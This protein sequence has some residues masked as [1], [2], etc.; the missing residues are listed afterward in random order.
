AIDC[1]V[2]LVVVGPR[3]W[4]GEEEMQYAQPLARRKR[5]V[6]FNHLSQSY[7]R[8]LYSGALFFA[9]PSFYEGFGLPPLD[10]MAHGCPVLNAHT[11]SLPEVCGDAALYADP[12]NVDD[13]ADKIRTMLRDDHLRRR[14]IEKGRER[15]ENF[16]SANFRSRVLEIYGKVLN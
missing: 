4:L 6:L 5:L 8:A 7:L 11:S 3:G 9:Y 13:L 2:P 1:E 15:A 16:S 12:F 14:L 10:A